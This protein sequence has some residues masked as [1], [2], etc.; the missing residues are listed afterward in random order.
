MARNRFTNPAN[1]AFYDWSINHESE[2]E[3]GKERSIEERSNTGNVGLTRTQ[4]A[5]GTLVLRY[6]GTILTRAQYVA[7]WQWYALCRTQTIY[8][9]D[10]D[11]QEYEVQITSFKPKRVRVAHNPRDAGMRLH[12]YEYTIEMH[13]YALRAGDLVGTGVVV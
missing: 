8:F 12:K 9:T 1:G 6:E 2:E 7:M 4:G 11:G 5:D 10:C 13:V 3:F